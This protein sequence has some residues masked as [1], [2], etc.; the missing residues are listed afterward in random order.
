MVRAEMLSVVSRDYVTAARALGA[1][2]LRI[3]TLHVAPN[4]KGPVLV[5]VTFA[6]RVRG[7]RGSVA[8][9]LRRRPRG[10]AVLGRDAQRREPHRRL[11]VALDPSRRALVLVPR[12]H[13]RGGGSAARPARSEARLGSAAEVRARRVDAVKCRPRRRSPPRSRYPTR[14]QTR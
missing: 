9:V 1:S 6:L 5:A 4:V 12:F 10:H 11:A 8:L 7:A 2:P 13:Q 3:L 14:Q